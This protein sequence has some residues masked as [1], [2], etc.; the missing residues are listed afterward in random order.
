MSISIWMC[1]VW[2]YSPKHRTWVVCLVV[3]ERE[4]ISYNFLWCRLVVVE[5]EPISYHFHTNSSL[6]VWE[7][8]LLDLWF[9]IFYFFNFPFLPLFLA[10]PTSSLISTQP[11]PTVVFL[12]QN[13]QNVIHSDVALIWVAAQVCYIIEFQKELVIHIS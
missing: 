7:I 12:E 3:V 8:F 1:C 13:L 11:N 6:L 2:K 9:F 10:L 5:W 4:P